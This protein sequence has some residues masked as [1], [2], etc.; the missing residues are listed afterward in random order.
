VLDVDPDPDPY[1]GNPGGWEG[2]NYTDPT[3]SGSGL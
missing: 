2:Q 1:I 3:G